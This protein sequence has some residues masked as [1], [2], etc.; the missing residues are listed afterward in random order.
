MNTYLL[1]TNRSTQEVGQADDKDL[2][3]WDAWLIG[4]FANLPLQDPQGGR[5]ISFGMVWLERVGSGG[6][7]PLVYTN[8]YTNYA[9]V[10]RPP[11]ND[12][13]SALQQWAPLLLAAAAGAALLWL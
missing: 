4:R 7:T 1:N 5:P 9:N 12:A 8:D 10:G 13:P 3:L 2:A 11:P 6:W